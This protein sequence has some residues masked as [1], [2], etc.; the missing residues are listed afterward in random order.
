MDKEDFIRRIILVSF[1]TMIIVSIFIVGVFQCIFPKYIE[2]IIPC[3]L[4]A[5]MYT[6]IIALTFFFYHT[7]N[8]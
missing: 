8:K 3:I 1:M 5:F 6:A 7:S 2:W 4:I